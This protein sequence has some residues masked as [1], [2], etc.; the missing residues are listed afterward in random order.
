MLKTNINPPLKLLY[1][2]VTLL[3]I[4]SGMLSHIINPAF[5][6]HEYLVNVY[7]ILP[8]IVAIY[9]LVAL[10]ERIN[11]SYA[12]YV[13]IMLIA[14]AYFLY[15]ILDRSATSYIIIITLLLGAFGVFDLFWW[16]ILGEAM[17][18]SKTPVSIFGRGLSAN[19]LGILIGTLIVDVLPAFLNINIKPTIIALLTVFITLISLPVLYNKIA[20]GMDNK[21]S[22]VG[23]FQSKERKIVLLR[24]DVD[25]SVYYK[26]KGLTDREVE[27]ADLLGKGGT[28]KMISKELNISKNT[29]KT[30]AKNLYS[31]L[32]ITSKDELIKIER[33]R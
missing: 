27:I 28:Y 17:A 15:F 5:A 31:K 7:W 11:K 14:M 33:D 9:I 1:A 30:H 32:G 22:L 25:L 10:P 24:S 29:V 3:S 19:V 16:T 12:L 2:F 26:N 20:L 13:S 18:F 8:Y 6:Q 4:N 21:G 23:L